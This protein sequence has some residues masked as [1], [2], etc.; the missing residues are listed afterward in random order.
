[1][2]TGMGGGCRGDHNI[3]LNFCLYNIRYLI[4]F[5]LINIVWKSNTKNP[6]R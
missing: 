3:I 1:M 5:N 4:L 2:Y 6:I